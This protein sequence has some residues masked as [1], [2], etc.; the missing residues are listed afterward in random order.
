[1]RGFFGFFTLICSM[2]LKLNVRFFTKQNFPRILL[3]YKVNIVILRHNGSRDAVA[4]LYTCPLFT[5]C[6]HAGNLR[7]FLD[8]ERVGYL[9]S[10]L[11]LVG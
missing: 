10:E 1:M 5:T 2:V 3:W 7:H 8:G 4:T 6:Y 9:A 11:R